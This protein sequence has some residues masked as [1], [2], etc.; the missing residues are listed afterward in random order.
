MARKTNSAKNAIAKHGKTI[1]TEEFLD[2]KSFRKHNMRFLRE[3]IVGLSQQELADRMGI[4]LSTIKEWESVKSPDRAPSAR[5]LRL[6]AEAL[7]CLPID[8]YSDFRAEY[9][10]GILDDM[11][12]VIIADFH[13]N[14][15]SNTLGKKMLA[16]KQFEILWVARNY[17]DSQESGI[18]PSQDSI[19]KEVE[20]HQKRYTMPNED[21]DEELE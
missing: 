3:R 13:Q 12:E 14:I 1:D 21:Q 17:Q 4:G 19:S 2:S 5:Y 18:P 9:L 20:M 8:L 16:M 10:A 15:R 11:L 6:L 7:N